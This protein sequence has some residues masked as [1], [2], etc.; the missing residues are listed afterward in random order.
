MS[1]VIALV[2]LPFIAGCGR[3]LFKSPP[4]T[5]TRLAHSDSRQQIV[6]TWLVRFTL[7][8][9]CMVQENGLRCSQSAPPDLSVEG[10]VVFTDTTMKNGP[11]GLVADLQFDLTPLLG[12]PVTCF[13]AGRGV[14]P[15]EVKAASVFIVFTPRAADCGLVAEGQLNTDTLVGEWREPAF[16]AYTA[17]GRFVIS[18][19]L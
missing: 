8:S 9:V 5:P 12:R 6:G 10:Q 1:R 7:D 18:R 15:V 4:A 2:V 13:R 16:V 11:K 17:A 3:P 14:I 19:R